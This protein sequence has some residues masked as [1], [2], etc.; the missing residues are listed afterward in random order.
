MNKNFLIEQ[1]RRL[2]V[3]HQ[4]ESYELTQEGLD[5]KW[6]LVHNNG[7]KQLIDEF[8]NLLEETEETDRKVLK[9]WLKKIIRLSN[10]V[11]SDLDKK[12]NNFKNDEDMS[13]EDEEVYHRNDGVLC[14]AYT[15]IN[16]IDKKRY[17][18]KL[19]RQK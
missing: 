11:I 16:I 6:L 15:L 2:D 4:K 14:I 7:H 8:V 19:Y 3:I 18:A 5:T 1:C 9:K 13:K 10:E 12:Y 17:I